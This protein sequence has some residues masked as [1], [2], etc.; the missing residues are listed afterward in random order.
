VRVSACE[1]G[2]GYDM[3]VMKLEVGGRN[4]VKRE[5]NQLDN[6]YLC[7]SVGDDELV[8]FSLLL[9]TRWR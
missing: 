6:R 9:R 4:I 3:A 8:T 7:V 5:R 1:S 2:G